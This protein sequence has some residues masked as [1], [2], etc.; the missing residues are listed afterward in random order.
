MGMF[1]GGDVSFKQEHFVCLHT[2]NMSFLIISNENCHS[3]P[4]RVKYEV[5]I[6]NL[7]ALRYQRHQA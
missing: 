7:E 2:I 3:H 6:T 5:N 4:N 1:F